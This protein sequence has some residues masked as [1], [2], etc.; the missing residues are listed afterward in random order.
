MMNP[1]LVCVLEIPNGDHPDPTHRGAMDGAPMRI[2]LE[3][4]TAP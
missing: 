3:E 4:K 1:V 2:S